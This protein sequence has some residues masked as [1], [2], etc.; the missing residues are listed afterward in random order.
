[1]K[2]IDNWCQWHKFWS[3]RLQLAGAAILTFVEGFPD[4]YISIWTAL[5]DDVRSEIPSNAVRW[6]GIAVIITGTFARFIKQN[7]LEQDARVGRKG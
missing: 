6:L 4:A 3:T 2:L 5:P 1:M 7:K